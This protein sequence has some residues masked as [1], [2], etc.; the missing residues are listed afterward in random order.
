MTGRGKYYVVWNGVQPGIYPSWEECRL[1]IEGYPD[2]K[3]KAFA[4]KQQAIEAYRGDPA[5]HIGILKF[6]ASNKD[7][8]STPRDY[9]QF[10][11]IRL[12]AI[13]VDGAC[14]SNPG[15]VEYRGVIVG[16][17]EEIF[18]VGPLN[19]GSN[20]IG[21]YLALVHA[22]ALLDKKGDRTTPVYADSRTS[23][24][25]LRNKGCRTKITPTDANKKT[26]E[27]IRRA[28]RWVQSHLQ[29]PNPVLKWD[30]RNWGEIPADFGRKH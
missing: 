5:K 20:N 4:T 24:S 7:S 6:I 21:E 17:G 2:A 22:L 10:P 19:D 11:E 25:W 18:R 30:T 3:Y 16:T 28:D 26:F 27:L 15:P 8:I 14:S 13:A 12:D 29:I 23:I 9:S 1:Q